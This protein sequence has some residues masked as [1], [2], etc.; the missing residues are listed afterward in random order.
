VPAGRAAASVKF[1]IRAK[2]IGPA[3]PLTVK[4]RGSKMSDAIKRTVEVVPD[5]K[6]IEQ[7]VTDRLSGKVTQTILIPDNA[8]PDASKLI[9]K[10]YPGVFSQVLEGVEGLIRL[11][12]G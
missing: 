2:K 9:V 8:L 6:K 1:R 10:V 11:P 5:G 4:A 3:Q 7:V 12:G